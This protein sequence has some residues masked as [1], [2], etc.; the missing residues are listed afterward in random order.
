MP[1]ACHHAIMPARSGL[2]HVHTHKQSRHA[3]AHKPARS[4]EPIRTQYNP[5]G[6]SYRAYS[7]NRQQTDTHTP[8]SISR[9]TRS[10]SFFIATAMPSATLR[11]RST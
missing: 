7:S 4:Q 11:Q 8:T 6:F 10:A 9:I 3:T 2:E 1:S 5:K